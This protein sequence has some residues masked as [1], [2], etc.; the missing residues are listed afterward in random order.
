MRL[1]IAVAAFVA[2]A[3]ASHAQDKQS[4]EL[5]AR[6]QYLTTVADCVACHTRPGGKAF[7]GGRPLETPFGTLL[8]PNITPNR[9][10]GIGAWTDDEFANSLHVGTGRGGEHIYPA[11]PYVYYTRTSRADAL[12]IR[13]Y[14]GTVEAV[15]NEV[16]SNQLPFPFS[17][18]ASLIGWNALFFKPGYFQP[19]AGKSAEWNRGASIVEGLGHCGMCHTPKNALGADDDSHHLQGYTLQGWFAPN[20]TNDARRGLGSWSEDDIVAYLATGHNKFAAASGPMAEEVTY[21]S[22]QMTPGDLRAI[23]VYLKDQG[24]QGG[25]QQAA[26][27]SGDAIMKTG[28]AIYVDNCSACHTRSG[29]GVAGLFPALKG[30]PSIQSVEPTSLIRV[31][32]IG[33]QSVSTQGNVTGAAMPALGWKLSDAQVAAVVTYIRNTWGNAAAPVAA[34]DVASQRRTLSASNE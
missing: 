24:D 4:F 19:V 34:S 26:V 30:A 5:I 16:H 1:A 14:L 25:A 18:R 23:A 21:S 28:E 2:A 31:V 33:A 9:A 29:A 7:A 27:P 15:D 20:I 6:G 22:S 10:T 11:M 32:L 12:A 13:A 3:T 17:I 8:T